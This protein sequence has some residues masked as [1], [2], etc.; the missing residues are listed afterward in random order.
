M[1]TIGFI[2]FKNY[3]ILANS[4]SVGIKLPFSGQEEAILHWSAIVVQKRAITMGSGACLPG[5]F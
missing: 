1:S 5:K 3:S 2:V 4:E